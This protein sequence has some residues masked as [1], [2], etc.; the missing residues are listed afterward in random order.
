MI[1]E[2]VVHHSKIGLP[3]LKWSGRAPALPAGEA[4]KGAED[5]EYAMSQAAQPADRRRTGI[6][7]SGVN[8]WSHLLGAANPRKGSYGFSAPSPPQSALMPVN[9]TTL[10]H[11]SVSSAISLLKSAREPSSTVPP[12]SASRA[13]ML[14][15]ARAALISLFSFSTIS[16][17]VAF[18]APTPYQLLAS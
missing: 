16:A 13:F 17:G 2:L 4:G 15:S 9:L 8:V 3:M 11:F 18:G 6:G 14:G 5:E 12:R 7:I 10:P 1:K